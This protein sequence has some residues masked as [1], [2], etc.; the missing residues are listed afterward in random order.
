MVRAKLFHHPQGFIS[1]GD[2]GTI[3]LSPYISPLNVKKMNLAQGRKYSIPPSSGR[4]NYLAYHREHI[5]KK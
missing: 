4:R 2:D 1:F 5:F 3:L